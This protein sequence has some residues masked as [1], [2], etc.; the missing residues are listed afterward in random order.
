MILQPG[1]TLKVDVPSLLDI[2]ALSDI[3]VLP[4]GTVQAPPTPPAQETVMS[5]T[6]TPV[7]VTVGHA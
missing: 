5:G 2:I 4:G 7:S 6:Q 1:Q 3:Q